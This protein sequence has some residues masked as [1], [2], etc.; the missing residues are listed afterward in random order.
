MHKS[1]CIGLLILLFTYV[2]CTVIKPSTNQHVWSD[3]NHL[4]FLDEYDVPFNAPFMNTTIGGLSGID[5]NPADKHY[6]LISDDRSEKNPARFY[7]ARIV[8]GDNKIDSVV[9][10]DVRFLKDSAGKNYPNSRTDPY[11]TP[12]PEALRF[13]PKSNTFI[14][15]SEGERIVK[16]EKLVLEDPA[17]TETTPEGKYIDTFEL[18]LQLHMHADESGPRQNSVFEG[19]TFDEQYKNLFVS[20]EEPL[21]NDG[22]RAGLDDSAGLNRILKFD[23][24]TKKPVAQYAYITDP[25]AHPATPANAFK[26]NGIPDIL[27]LGNNKLLVIERSFSTGRMACTIK[28]FITDLSPAEN[29]SDVASLKSKMELHTATKKLLFNMDDIGIYIDNIEGV[30]FGPKLADGKQSLIFVSDNNFNPLQKTQFLLF[31]I[32]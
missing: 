4:K 32:E 9:F 17:V 15:S 21:Y 27:Y 26:I 28:V 3:S 1:T 19:V 5:Y 11:H 2:S 20:V 29:I 23:M 10:T 12:D 30:T 6:Y 22:P 13:D 14:W 8:L 16:P 7:V 31:E 25:I 24:V 18:P